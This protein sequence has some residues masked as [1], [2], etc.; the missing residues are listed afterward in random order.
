[1]TVNRMS[2][3]VRKR[4]LRAQKD[5]ATSAIVYSR[6]SMREN[7]PENKQILAVIAD[8]ETNHAAI[9]E[10]Y[11][12][13][14]V[15]HNR[16]Q[17]AWYSI[18]GWLLGYTFVIQLM[19]R[20]EAFTER[21]YEALVRDIPEM[22]GI[23]KEEERHEAEL[24]TMLD[25]ERL[26]Y[27]GAMV[28]GLN[29]ALVELTGTIAGLTLA[30]Q[31]NRLVALAG[32]ITGISA[33]L[34]MAA[35]NYLAERANGKKDAVR[36]SCYTGVAYLITV[37]LLVLPYLILPEHRYFIALIAMLITVVLIIYF[38]NYYITTAQKTPFWPRFREM[39]A[40]S[41]AVAAISFVIGLIA[42]S[43]LGV[44]I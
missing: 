29:D 26:H 17:V 5:E 3:S 7:S 35:S 38:F 21:E 36:S 40:I 6:M 19:E 28:L 44:D 24:H 12:G 16:W 2:D 1:M 31:N 20:N 23:I 18:L 27:V 22:R 8:D 42:K 13:K 25:E 15:G 10:K 33:T 39:A 41:L 37:V 11:S 9:L 30:L 14:H 32:I 34:S 43:L 4:V